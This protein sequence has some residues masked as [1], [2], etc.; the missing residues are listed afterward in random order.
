M[1]APQGDN[2]LLRVLVIDDQE[3]VRN[4]VHSV[5]KRIGITNVVDAADGREALAAVTEPG[6]WFDL[7]LCDLRMPGRDG[8]ETI[9]AFSALGLE[10]AFVIMSVEE[11]RILETAGVLAEVQGLHLL[12]TVPKPLTIEKLEPLL[13]RIRNIPGKNALGAPLA[14]E[15]DLRAAFIGNELTLMYQPK[16]SLRSGE[17]AGAEALVRWKHPTLGLFQPAAFIPIIEESDDYSAMLTEFCL[18]EA[19][20]CAGRWTAAGQPLSVA[21]NLSPRAFDRLDLPERVEALAKDANVSPDHIT[22]EVTETQIERDAVR[23]IDVATRLRLKGFRLSIDD[24]GTGQ[25]G[26]AKLQTLPFNE[27]KIDRRFVDGCASSAA[28]RAVVQASLALSQSLRMVSV[29]EGVQQRPDWDL[30][31]ELG[32]DVMQGFFIA[33]PMT[34]D[35]LAAWATQWAIRQR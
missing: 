19:I 27:L 23:M 12:G 9:R 10:S 2:S 29:A 3:H 22:L 31:T 8:I 18:C 26:L 11:E 1:T 33:R 6:S 25:S 4:W 17:F 5:L 15:S 32:C 14:P 7:I 16:V 35:G 28:K 13:A 30:L 34:E 24:F 21:I 20:A